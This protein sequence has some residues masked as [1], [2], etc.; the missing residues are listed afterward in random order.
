MS[1]IRIFQNVPHDVFK[2]GLS[3]V[4]GN[5]VRLDLTFSGSAKRLDLGDRFRVFNATVN[6]QTMSVGGATA[7]LETVAAGVSGGRNIVCIGDSRTA[8]TTGLTYVKLLKDRFGSDLTLL[9]TQGSGDWTHEG[10]SGR[11]Y[12]WFANDAASPL[13]DGSGNIDLA[14]YVSTIGA[15]P[16]F[17]VMWSDVNGRSSIIS[18]GTPE[19]GWD[20]DIAAEVA[21]IQALID[22][23]HAVSSS[24]KVVVA[25]G[26]IYGLTDAD[27]VSYNAAFTAGSR[28]RFRRFMFHRNASLVTDFGGQ[29]ASNTYLFPMQ[30]AVDPQGDF[31]NNDPFHG[32]AGTSGGRMRMHAHIE[33]WLAALLTDIW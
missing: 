5:D 13:T 19:N 16:D 30:L 31:P 28:D 20:A 2:R 23:W 15:T 27:W 10:H 8:P 12:D 25:M 4:D 6:Q 29:E 21:D 18:G 3:N 7:T 17:V 33:R 22:A 24:I 32:S 11:N 26:P 1:A 9:G 14:S